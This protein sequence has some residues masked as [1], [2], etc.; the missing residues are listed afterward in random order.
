MEVTCP[1]CGL[2]FLADNGESGEVDHFSAR[3]VQHAHEQESQGQPH[4]GL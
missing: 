4:R 1:G 2:T 3:I